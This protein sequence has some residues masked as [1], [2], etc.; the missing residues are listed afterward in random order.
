[1]ATV[2]GIRGM[3]GLALIALLLATLAACNA[4]FNFSDSEPANTPSEPAVSATSPN[5]IQPGDGGAKGLNVSLL[6]YTDE[7]IGPVYVNGE[8][9]GGMGK[10]GGGTSIAGGAEVPD[11][12][13]AD[14][15]LKIS[16]SDD[17]LYREDPN[18]LYSRM[19]PLEPYAPRDGGFL[20]VAFF[21]NDVIKLYASAYGP[22]NPHWP[23]KKMA[24]GIQ[25][26]VDGFPDCQKGI[27][28]WL[29]EH[30]TNPYTGEPWQFGN[31]EAALP[32][33]RP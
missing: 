20:W 22:G 15:K 32:R 7:N 16:W 31:A 13:R 17:A 12:W 26:V 6:N 29:K 14:Y 5:R 4:S 21:P 27:A 33:S 11:K 23:G 1:M 25:C 2:K 24:P 10:H 9:A 8:W 30:P 18:R 3:F 28:E 19:V